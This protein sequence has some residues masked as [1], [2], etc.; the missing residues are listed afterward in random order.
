MGGNLIAQLTNPFKRIKAEKKNL[1]LTWDALQIH[2]IN[3]SS[4]TVY[5]ATMRDKACSHVKNSNKPQ[6]MPSW[7]G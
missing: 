5:S 3:L 4:K 7:F 1:M 6:N 2:S